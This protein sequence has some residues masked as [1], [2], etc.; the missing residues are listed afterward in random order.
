VAA[1]KG[2]RTTGYVP[3]LSR[4]QAIVERPPIFRNKGGERIELCVD[5]HESLNDAGST[6]NQ[7]AM[8]GYRRATGS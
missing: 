5:L 2:R 7:R 1:F 3:G 8:F 4:D 6:S